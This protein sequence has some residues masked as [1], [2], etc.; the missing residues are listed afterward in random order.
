MTLEQRVT[1]AAGVVRGMGHRTLNDLSHAD[2]FR[3]A[4]RLGLTT[5]DL[6]RAWHARHGVA[7]ARV[8]LEQLKRGPRWRTPAAATA[9]RST[10]SVDEAR[11]AEWFADHPELLRAIADVSQRVGLRLPTTAA[12]GHRLLAVI[13]RVGEVSD[14]NRRDAL[15]SMLDRPLS[16]AVGQQYE[17]E[18]AHR[19]LA[20]QAH[21]VLAAGKRG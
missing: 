3:L 6:H 13:K 18:D 2:Q 15:V 1:D 19:S 4:D 12:P 20:R 5:S 11:E 14:K 21:A 7:A 8:E 9:P 17:L 16:A 10:S